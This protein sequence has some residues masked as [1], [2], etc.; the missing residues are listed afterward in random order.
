MS[1]FPCTQC[2]LCCQHVG[3]AIASKPYLENSVVAEA[4]DAFPYAFDKNGVCEKFIN[5]QCSVYD[6]RPVICNVDTMA[7][8]RGFDKKYWYKVNAMA[9][10][11]MIRQAGLDDSYLIKDYDLPN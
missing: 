5:N 11:F 8:L 7:E 6:N 9:C 10:N 3:Q 1:S 4:I 2:G